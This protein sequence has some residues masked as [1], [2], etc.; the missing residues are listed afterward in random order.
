MHHHHFHIVI[1]PLISF[2]VMRNTRSF[3]WAPRYF[4]YALALDFE[5]R[6][7][8][9]LFE[10]WEHFLKCLSPRPE[11]PFVQWLEADDVDL[12]VKSILSSGKS[13]NDFLSPSHLTA[14][15]IAPY[16]VT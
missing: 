16:L 13:Y 5:G 1:L 9:A 14:N 10:I 12:C 2:R 4:S 8:E 11:D 6:H 15:G 3:Y 7:L